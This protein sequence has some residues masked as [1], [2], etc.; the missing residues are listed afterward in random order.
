MTRT[1]NK[2]GMNE[3]KTGQQR[4]G[5]DLRLA[6]ESPASLG[7]PTLI[8]QQR[9]IWQDHTIIKIRDGHCYG[10]GSDKNF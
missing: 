2:R 10:N 8:N 7:G 6:R 3:E 9:L 5:G 1:K 4:L